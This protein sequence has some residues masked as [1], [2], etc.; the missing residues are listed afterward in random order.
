YRKYPDCIGYFGTFKLN[1][2]DWS[3]S[4]F[5]GSIESVSH[6]NLKEKYESINIYE[7]DKFLK[8]FFDWS[9]S[10][11]FLWSAWMVKREIV[12]KIWWVP[13]YWYAN[14]SDYAYIIQIWSEWTILIINK[15]LWINTIHSS[16]YTR[17][18]NELYKQFVEVNVAY[19]NYLVPI[20]RKINLIK[21]FDNFVVK[22]LAIWLL[23]SYL[24]NLKHSLEEIDRIMDS[25]DILTTKFPSL[26]INKNKFLLKLKFLYYFDWKLFRW[27][28]FKIIKKIINLKL[29]YT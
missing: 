26:K 13:D 27:L 3:K 1:P 2:L 28:Y 20:I 15:E 7:S 12:E 19:Y 10:S 17:N 4:N 5:W 9:I 21:E 16:N 23:W 14:N 24:F 18:N 6:L 29:K 22:H 11:A 25:Y 8:W